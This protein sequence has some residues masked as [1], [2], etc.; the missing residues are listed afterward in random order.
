VKVED[1]RDRQR[2]VRKGHD[3]GEA[4]R[5]SITKA[6]EWAERRRSR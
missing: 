5:I 3:E 2:S 6:K 1:D 4:I